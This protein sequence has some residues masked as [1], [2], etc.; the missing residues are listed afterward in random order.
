[1]EFATFSF[2]DP[3]MMKKEF[4]KVASLQTILHSQSYLETMP[5]KFL[6]HN[7]FR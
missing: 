7:T 3:Q 5:A 1:M 2:F 4:W 6:I